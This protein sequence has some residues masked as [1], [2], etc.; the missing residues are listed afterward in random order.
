MDDFVTQLQKDHP[1]PQTINID[2]M[3]LP[4]DTGDS[5][6]D[7]LKKMFPVQP[8]ATPLNQ[9]PI[10]PPEKI[11][12]IPL[13]Y[14]GTSDNMI[15]IND[16]RKIHPVTGN[17]INP[18]K[19][20]ISG[21]FNK[22]IMSDVIEEA[23]KVGYDPYKALAVGIFESRLGYADENIGHVIY[24]QSGS[25]NRTDVSISPYISQMVNTLKYW[26]DKARKTKK[27][28]SDEYALQAYNSPNVL[29]DKDVYLTPKTEK[30]Y[31]SPIPGH[32]T[33]SFYGIDVTKKPLNLKENPAYGK[34]IKS[35]SDM[36]R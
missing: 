29:Q 20:F 36:L 10:R 27:Y 24:P 2:G 6:V 7:E 33:P 30:K 22:G 8:N 26:D 31:L 14:L 15:R 16:T 18:N 28:N 12:N 11:E 1:L 3:E 32:S 19:D 23:K 25:S 35:I 13:K 34:T 5:H 9:E 17:P 4:K 21:E